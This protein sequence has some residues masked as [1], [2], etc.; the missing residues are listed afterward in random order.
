MKKTLKC[1]S[2]QMLLVSLFGTPIFNN[3]KCNLVKA[4]EIYYTNLNNISMTKDEYDK[5]INLGFREI[6]IQHIS[7][8]QFNEIQEMK[9]LY[10][11]Y[12]DYEDN[13]NAR[14][15]EPNPDI[16]VYDHNRY[17]TLRG[18]YYENYNGQKAYFIKVDTSY[19]FDP[20]VQDIAYLAIAMEDNVMPM[21]VSETTLNVYGTFSYDENYCD[22]A[23]EKEYYNVFDTTSHYYSYEPTNTSKYHYYP[24][25]SIAMV[26]DLPS[27]IQHG[28]K[29]IDDKRIYR[30]TD[31]TN[32]YM[33]MYCYFIPES[34]DITSTSFTGMHIHKYL[35]FNIEWDGITF[36]SVPPYIKTSAN[37]SLEDETEVIARNLYYSSNITYPNC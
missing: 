27:D 20:S 30:K 5:L 12:G 6:E 8:E 3:V 21:P 9:I 25:E 4:E 35:N 2:I 13:I 14:S 10:T 11:L 16:Y 1:L 31:Y 17:Y 28:F 22:M 32:F 19:T 18:T 24:D 7:V 36:I 15:H 26:F 34:P 33:S 23:L 37:I 29:D